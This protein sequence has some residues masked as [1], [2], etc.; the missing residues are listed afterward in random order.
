M[1]R[2]PD[3]QTPDDRSRESYIAD[4]VEPQWAFDLGDDR[5]IDLMVP[6]A[7][8]LGF[9]ARSKDLNDLMTTVHPVYRFMEEPEI[10]EDGEYAVTGILP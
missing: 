4:W 5:V 7:Y 10:L 8:N 3:G 1:A 9:V 2:C 6:T